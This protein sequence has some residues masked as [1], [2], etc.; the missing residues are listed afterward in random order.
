MRMPKFPPF[1]PY[2]K[3]FPKK[4]DALLD[5]CQEFLQKTEKY[6]GNIHDLYKAGEELASKLSY[7]KNDLEILC[8]EITIPE[9]EVSKNPYAPDSFLGP[10]EQYLGLYIAALTNKII[11]EQDILILKP[12]A[13]LFGLGAFLKKGRIIIEGDTRGGVGYH[14][15]GGG[16]IVNGNAKDYVGAGMEGGEIRVNGNVEHGLGTFMKGGKIIVEGS[17]KNNA[18]AYLKRGEIRIGGDVEK[19]TAQ[20][21]RGGLMTI[22]GNAGRSTGFL[23]NGGTVIVYGRIEDISEDCKGKIIQKNYTPL[24]LYKNDAERFIKYFSMMSV[25]KKKTILD[26]I[27]SYDFTNEEVAEWLDKHEH[28]LVREVGLSP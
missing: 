6:G 26:V 21:M 2:R 1:P 8:Q 13:K 7:T 23:M 14:M 20:G 5:G 16:I 18:G 27:M 9:T 19:Y 10:R 22:G 25:D 24:Q 15:S 28:N 4:L 17:A 11:R 3:K 12:K